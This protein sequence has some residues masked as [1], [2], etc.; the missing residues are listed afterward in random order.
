MPPASLQACLLHSEP[1]TVVW[2]LVEVRTGE[3]A[4]PS[5][6]A[7]KTWTAGLLEPRAC[8]LALRGLASL[9]GQFPI[10][11]Q[12]SPALVFML[13]SGLGET[14]VHWLIFWSFLPFVIAHMGDPG[15]PSLH[16]THGHHRCFTLAQGV[17]P[18]SLG[19][20]RASGSLSVLVRLQDEAIECRTVPSATKPLTRLIPV[21]DGH[22][23]KRRLVF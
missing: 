17:P 18:A 4:S 5:S 20:K 12:Q 23:Q 14:L 21:T 13:E 15:S 11:M 9:G 16:L 22:R 19:S 1:F 6:P 8:C 3:P 10:P 2:R 7:L